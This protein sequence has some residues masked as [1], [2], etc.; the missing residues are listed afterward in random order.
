MLLLTPAVLQSLQPLQYLLPN[1][2]FLET[3]RAV[4]RLYWMA[5]QRAECGGDEQAFCGGLA[6]PSVVRC[7]C[8]AFGNT[9]TKEP[10]ENTY[11]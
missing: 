10:L 9:N 6:E 7:E 2:Q 3:A 4:F 1:C 8:F 11:I 5:V